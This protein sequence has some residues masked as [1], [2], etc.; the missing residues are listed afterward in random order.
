MHTRRIRWLVVLLAAF[1][2]LVR[3]WAGYQCILAYILKSLPVPLQAFFRHDIGQDTSCGW[4]SE[5]KQRASFSS[6]SFVVLQVP[7]LC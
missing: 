4:L 6:E 2:A 7:L 3:S 1:S 5:L